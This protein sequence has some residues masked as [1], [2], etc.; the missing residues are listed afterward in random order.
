MTKI[1]DL[2]AYYCTNCREWHV[3]NK[4]HRMNKATFDGHVKYQGWPDLELVNK[5][6]KEEEAAENNRLTWREQGAPK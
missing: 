4:T 3:R 6:A 2:S 1:I 5:W